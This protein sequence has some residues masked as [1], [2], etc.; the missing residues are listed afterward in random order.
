MG[1]PGRS[2]H[3]EGRAGPARGRGRR[4]SRGDAKFQSSAGGVAAPRGWSPFPLPPLR[5][6]GALQHRGQP[7]RHPPLAGGTAAH[8][9]NGEERVPGPPDFTLTALGRGGRSPRTEARVRVAR[10]FQG[11]DVATASAPPCPLLQ[12]AKY[13]GDGDWLAGALSCAEL[14]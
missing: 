2:A 1:P 9:D 8:T 4:G 6:R 13:F 11:V 7:L 3:G 12:L 10:M 5:G 14:N